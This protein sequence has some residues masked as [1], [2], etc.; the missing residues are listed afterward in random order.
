MTLSESLRYLRLRGLLKTLIKEVDMDLTKEF[1][2][3]QQKFDSLQKTADLVVRKPMTFKPYS[4]YKNKSYNWCIGNDN[5]FGTFLSA[6]YFFKSQYGG[7]L[8]IT[9]EYLSKVVTHYND[10]KQQWIDDNAVAFKY[11][12]GVLE[13]NQRQFNYVKHIMSVLGVSETN[14]RT[15]FKTPRS[16]TLTIEKTKAL[17]PDEV[18]KV[19]P[20]DC[21]YSTIIKTIDDKLESIKKFAEK[22]MK[23]NNERIIKEK[24][25]KEKQERETRKLRVL[26]GLCVKYGLDL[27]TEAKEILEHL[28]LK[29]KYL[30]LAYSLEQNRNDWSNGCNYAWEGIK[31]FKI[32]T[33]TDKA[34]YEEI[35]E[36]C[37]D[38][39]D[40]RVFR[41]CTWNYNK[42]YSMA[43]ESLTKDLTSITEYVW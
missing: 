15:F 11:N 35:F 8:Y 6:E 7:G 10:A 22:W 33:E 19:L 1:E 25:E 26:S 23:D 27:D 20:L 37:E 38:F 14:T 42:L 16:K 9:P 34:I 30:S 24:T 43:D 12:Q 5:R 40:G 21:G 4:D 41:D 36:I 2:A 29:D 28:L 13:H 32:E 17:W 31:Y 39:T 18:A 3:I